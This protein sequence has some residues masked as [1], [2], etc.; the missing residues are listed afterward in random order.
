MTVKL[1]D[2]KHKDSKRRRHN[3]KQLTD[4]GFN[5]YEANRF[6]DYSI[7]KIVSLIEARKSFND[8]IKEL[9]GGKHA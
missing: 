8:S 2:L 3:Y 4:A 6:K 7:R 1:T 9:A 5:S